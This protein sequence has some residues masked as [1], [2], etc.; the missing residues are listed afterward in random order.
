MLK[1]SNNQQ[2]IKIIINIGELGILNFLEWKSSIKFISKNKKT[3]KIK[4]K[5]IL[6]FIMIFSSFIITIKA[7]SKYNLPYQ[8]SD[9]VNFLIE[10][11]NP[12]IVNS[13]SSYS[14]FHPRDLNLNTAQL[15]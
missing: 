15:F 4:P 2:S 12:F 7:L 10:N 11:N 9:L 1:S 13:K 8:N 14:Y 5:I 3:K 6:F